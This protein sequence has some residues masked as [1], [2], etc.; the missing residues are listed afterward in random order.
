M[1]LNRGSFHGSQSMT[2]FSQI[3]GEEIEVTGYEI[4]QMKGI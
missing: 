3:E 1:P 4:S 2:N